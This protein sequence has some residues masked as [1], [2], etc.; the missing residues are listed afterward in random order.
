VARNA[1]AIFLL[2]ACTL[3]AAGVM[4]DMPPPGWPVVVAGY[5]WVLGVFY[6]LRVLDDLKDR[7]NDIIAYPER[8]LSRGLLSYR[9]LAYTGAMAVALE[10]AAAA[11]LGPKILIL[12]AV[13]LA[14]SLLMYREFFVSAWLRRH[15]FWYGFIHMLVLCFIDFTI[16]QAADARGPVAHA[17]GFFLFATLSFVMTF[18]L[19]VSRKIRVPAAE[20]PEVDTYSKA[21]GVRGS[22]ALVSIF[23]GFVLAIA[24]LLRDALRMPAWFY[25]LAAAAWLFVALVG[26]AWGG[27]LTPER[28]LK[29]EKV[30]SVFFLTFYFALLA[31]LL[32]P[33]VGNAWGGRS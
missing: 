31:S 12:H 13:T 33:L 18:S 1:L 29:L 7:A 28:S 20:R 30:A 14:Y 9:Q 26:A 22:I 8:V 24:W 2:Y 3:L 11:W 10:T 4:L 5:V 19:E 27:S 32:A 21:V 15:L 25:P 6:H 16:L 17:A 23:Q